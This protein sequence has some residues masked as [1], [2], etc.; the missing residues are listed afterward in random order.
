MTRRWWAWFAL[1]GVLAVAV[2][3]LVPTGIP[4]DVAYVSIGLASVA[5][6][7]VG[8]RLHHPLRRAPWVLMLAG[9]LLWV[10][11]DAIDSWHLDV[12]GSEA[13]PSTADIFYLAAYPVLA[14][15]LFLMIRGRLPRYDPAGLLDSAT[16]TAGL[17]L[18]SWVLLAKPTILTAQDS[19]SA[20]VVGVAYPLAD[21]VLVGLLIRLAMTPG[22]RTPAF[23]FLLSAVFLLIAGDATSDVLSY[24]TS[25]TTHYVDL[26][27]L[28]SYVAWGTAALHP[29]MP[30]LTEPV[31]DRDVSFTR[32]RLGALTIATL[33]APG[34]LAVQAATGRVLDVW[35][36]VVG[37]VT[38]FLLVV[39][40]MWVA[41]GQIVAANHVRDRLREDL[42]Y[43]AAHD[44]LTG[45]PNRAQA[46]DLITG[47]LSRAQRSGAIVGLLFIDLDGFKAVNDTYGHAAGDEVLRTV[48]TRLRARIRAGDVIARLGG[49][50]FVVLLENLATE[51]AAVEAADALVHEA[52][53][54]IP[55]GGGREA[56][57]GASVG[58]AVNHDAQVDA[59]RLLHEA[60]TAVYRAKQGGRGRTEVFDAGLRRELAEIADLEA[61]MMTAIATD[62]LEL[63]YQPIVLASTG[64]V[65]GYEALVRWNRPG[66]GLVPPDHFIPLAE[67]SNLI[68]DIDAWVLNRATAQLATWSRSAP[69]RERPLTMAVNVSARHISHPRILDDVATALARSGIAPSQLTLEITETA[70]AEDALLAVHHLD[71]LRALGVE[72]SLDDFGTGY[73]SVAR[74]RNL[75]VDSVKIDRSFLDP[76]QL[77]SFELFEFILHAAHAFNLTVIAEGVETEE[78][79]MHLQ[80]LRC[81]S[82]QGFYLGR[83]LAATSDG[84]PPAPADV[85]AA[86]P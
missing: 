14:V 78:Q 54:P 17:G 57:V 75:P 56:R 16:L 41:I 20:A 2:Y 62:Q 63:H 55:V 47:A 82:A 70:L 83:P 44:S 61:A 50:E 3:P 80:D 42:A 12:Q 59:E 84:I 40:R 6:I 72:I 23:R 66:V 74:L 31:T 21:I 32:A 48:A 64:E 37:S 13:F 46:L 39:A 9:Q 81:E 11:G 45:L 19:L 69:P 85:E 29:S 71:Q 76:A 8:V 7:G 1:S 58:V 18:L 53:R 73:S 49:D 43:Q 52:S 15:G 68:H 65:Q 30:T 34:T 28:L 79:L 22:G 35:P 10:I 33:V 51:A 38:M 67:T 24:Y 5:A 26:L 36:V 4:H 77:G 60:D 86:A 27:W 25:S